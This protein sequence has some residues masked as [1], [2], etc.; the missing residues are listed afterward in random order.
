MKHKPR[1]I[2]AA[3]HAQRLRRKAVKAAMKRNGGTSSQLARKAN[4]RHKSQIIN[5]WTLPLPKGIQTRL[6]RQ[7]ALERAN[8]KRST[9]APITLLPAPRVMALWAEMRKTA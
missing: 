7:T 8:R 1:H 4:K 6:P 5:D 2:R 3:R 9:V